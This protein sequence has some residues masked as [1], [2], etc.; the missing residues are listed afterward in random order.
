MGACRKKPAQPASGTLSW[1]TPSETLLR[2]C[3]GGFGKIFAKQR[4]LLAFVRFHGPIFETEKPF[5]NVSPQGASPVL[6]TPPLR[7]TLSEGARAPQYMLKHHESICS[8]QVSFKEAVA[9]ARRNWFDT[10]KM[11]RIG[12]YLQHRGAVRKKWL[13]RHV[14]AKTSKRIQKSSFSWEKEYTSELFCVCVRVAKE[15]R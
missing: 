6:R 11:P 10:L 13:M 9:Q 1:M 14:A 12:M 4:L 8:P 15:C 3:L 5:E 7:A 2:L